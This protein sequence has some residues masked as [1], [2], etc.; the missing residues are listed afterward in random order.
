MPKK[1]NYNKLFPALRYSKISDWGALRAFN[2]GGT[3][4]MLHTFVF[5]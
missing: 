4:A 2:C 5:F 3:D 1:P